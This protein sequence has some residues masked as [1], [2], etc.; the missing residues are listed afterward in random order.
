MDQIRN[1]LNR[2]RLEK[3]S[4][5]I[6]MINS[7]P[8][9]NYGLSKS[10][11]INSR[12]YTL[13]ESNKTLIPIKPTDN[14]INFLDKDVAKISEIIDTDKFLSVE[15]LDSDTIESYLD[16]QLRKYLEEVSEIVK[17]YLDM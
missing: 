10:H 2:V 7:L 3:I 8:T 14:I 9:E 5:A 13:L 17:F 11:P 6:G 12:G 4:Q 15:M 1:D 16:S